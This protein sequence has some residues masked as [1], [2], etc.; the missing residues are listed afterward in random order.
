ML[1]SRFSALAGVRFRN[2]KGARTHPAIEERRLLV[3]GQ[4]LRGASK[5]GFG[6]SR[7]R[8]G[9]RVPVGY[10]IA[11]IGDKLRAVMELRI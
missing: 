3:T 2:A 7:N 10:D 6:V 9:A 11:A 5:V 1:T 8:K 4:P